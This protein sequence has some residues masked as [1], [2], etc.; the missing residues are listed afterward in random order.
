MHKYKPHNL[1]DIADSAN[2]RCLPLH[3]KLMWASQTMD[4]LKSKAQGE[5]MIDWGMEEKQVA[6]WMLFMLTLL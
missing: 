5:C 1:R 6:I 2:Q 3:D 4:I